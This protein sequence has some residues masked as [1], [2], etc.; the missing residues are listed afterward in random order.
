MILCCLFFYEFRCSCEK[1]MTRVM[2]KPIF[3][4]CENKPG[5]TTTEDGF[6]L[7]I[8]NLGSMGI[9]LSM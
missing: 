9:V 4:I 8:K 5:C 2:R 7:E 6:G 3:C 1:Y